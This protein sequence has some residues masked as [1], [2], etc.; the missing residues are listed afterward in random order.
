M[1]NSRFRVGGEMPD[2][3]EQTRWAD[4]FRRVMDEV[5]PREPV[6]FPFAHHRG[7]EQVKY[8]VEAGK[9]DVP[10]GA[11]NWKIVQVKKKARDG[12]WIGSEMWVQYKKKVR[13]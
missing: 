6:C 3:T 8:R 1:G 9:V 11:D 10:G 12:E 7:A 13:E 4:E 2:A 5:G